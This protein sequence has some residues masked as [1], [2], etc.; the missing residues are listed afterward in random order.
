M[1]LAC[2]SVRDDMLAPEFLAG[3]MTIANCW[4]CHPQQTPSDHIRLEDRRRR[5][6]AS[7]AVGVAAGGQPMG[8]AK[9]KSSVGVV[10]LGIM[11]GAFA[12]NLVADGWRV[13]GH[14]IDPARRRALAKAGVEMTG[15]ATQL[16][17]AV[18][19]IITSLP[20][21]AA[22]AATVAAIVGARA[23]PL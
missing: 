23:R 20:S 1:V 8:R 16:A 14:D 2:A 15:D 18:R 19:T 5:C 17:G 21:P 9:T 3:P 22:L 4:T 13:I 11:G 6:V 7:V 10:G 12:R